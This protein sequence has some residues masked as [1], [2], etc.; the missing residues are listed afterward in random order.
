M[1]TYWLLGLCGLVLSLT[2]T[3]CGG[4]FAS[5]ATTATDVDTTTTTTTA[6][7]T[8]TH[9]RPVCVSLLNIGSCNTTQVNTQQ[10]NRPAGL[11][12][13]QSSGPTGA[14]TVGTLVLL[15]LG[16]ILVIGAAGAAMGSRGYN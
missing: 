8:Q 3:G 10:V 13:P 7:Q 6:A 16:F 2:L 14:Q 15:C 9:N 12:A 4:D 11:P 5:P 1:K